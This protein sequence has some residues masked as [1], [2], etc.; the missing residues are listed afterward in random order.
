[1]GSPNQGSL[2][3]FRVGFRVQV[4]RPS[5]L[6][7]QPGRCDVLNPLSSSGTAVRLCSFQNAKEGEMSSRA[8]Y[9]P[10]DAGRGPGCVGAAAIVGLLPDG[11]TVGRMKSNECAQGESLG[12]KSAISCENAAV[13][14]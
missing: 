3:E 7:V 14:G 4:G 10:C 8:S 6:S 5:P 12:G 1:M 2:R 9:V 13:C 11:V